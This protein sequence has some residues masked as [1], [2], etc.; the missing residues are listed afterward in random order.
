MSYL[1]RLGRRLLQEVDMATP[2][3]IK[4]PQSGMDY[5][6]AA[7]MLA[8]LGNANTPE[9]QVSKIAYW[10]NMFPNAAGGSGISGYAPGTPVNPTATQNIYDLYYGNPNNAALAL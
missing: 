9:S 3:D 1:G 7:T 5:F 4:D 10:E 2:L 8:K 6:Q